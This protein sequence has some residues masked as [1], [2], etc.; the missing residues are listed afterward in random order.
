MWLYKEETLMRISRYIVEPVYKAVRTH[1]N[2][3]KE[4]QERIQEQENMKKAIRIYKGISID[5]RV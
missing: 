5:E 4:M 2:K 1:N 3:K